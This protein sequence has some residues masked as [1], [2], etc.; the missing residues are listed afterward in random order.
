MQRPIY[1]R[2]ILFLLLAALLFLSPNAFAQVAE[3]DSVTFT[4]EN[5]LQTVPQQYEVLGIE[6]T[7][8]TTTRR[9]F[10]IS[11]L[12]FQTGSTIT[13][14]GPDVSSAIERLYRTGLFTNI[15]IIRQRTTPEGIYLEVR[16][17]ERPKLETYFITGVGGSERE[18]IRDRLNIL[19]GFAVT[20]ATKVQ[21]VNTIQR[22]F[23]NE[24]HW[25]TTVDVRTGEVD[26]VRNTVILYFDVNPGE[27]LE[28]K[29][30]DFRGNEA[31]GDGDLQDA[32][33]EI[34]EDKWW[35]F[36][37]K[38]TI[39]EEKLETAKQNLETFYEAHG[40]L[41]FRITADSV[42]TFPYIQDRLF[43]FNT[44]ATG[45]KV[46][47]SVFE[48]EQYHVSDINWVGNTL[49]TDEQLSEVLGFEQGDVFNRTEFEQ[50]LRF[51]QGGADVTSLYQNRGYLFFT[52]REEIEFVADDSV[53]VTINI[54]EG[55]IATIDE[56]S[57]TGNVETH[58][59]VIRRNLHTIP[60]NTYSR[61]AVIRTVREL[62]TIGYF[63][64]AS[65]RPNLMP[66]RENN[67]VDI[68]Y[69]V[70]P[71]QSTDT[72]EFSGGYG[73]SRI[74]LILSA[75]VS[76]GNFSL[77]RA[78]NGEGWNPIPSGD[79]QTLSL[80][81]QISG[82]GYQSYSFSFTEPW[83][84]GRP[85]SLGISASYNVLSII[86][87]D[88]TNKLL[89]T[90]VS[91]GRRLDWPD[92]YFTQQTILNYRLYDISGGRFLLD[93][94]RSATLGLTSVIERNSLDN[95]IS[96]TR[97]SKLQLTTAVGIPVP[98][99]RQYYKVESLFAWHTTLIGKLV[100][101]TS[102]QYGYL[103]YFSD[104]NRSNFQRYVLGGTPLQQ[105]QSFLTDNIS[106]RG[107]PGGR[108]Q[109]IAPRICE[110]NAPLGQCPPRAVRQVGGR[111]FSKYSLELRIPLV[112]ERQ[113][114]VIPYTFFDA[115]NAYLNFET[116]A[117][118]EVKRAT[119]FG[120]RIYLP[121]LGL[122]DLS[123]GYR[124]DSIPATLLDGSPTNDVMAGEWQF[125]FNLGTSF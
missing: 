103:G 34:K 118:F 2:R 15:K 25:G 106:L 58:D 7:G 92:D 75:R 12:G 30:I 13:V 48:G 32:L 56:V 33:G 78:L 66:N 101:T 6:V 40:Y 83:L 35:K 4:I 120:V 69:T 114:Q 21:G 37:S 36:F 38:K 96:P 23:K 81:I 55:E 73:G 64:P 18:D 72:F 42:Y 53:D 39:T 47:L 94:G 121:I 88:Q 5:P 123:Y 14:P 10:V 113:I 85:N 54:Y 110:I 17:Q 91:L 3:D 70:E 63:R 60:G 79:G 77:E 19:P 102:V 24:G 29:D 99:L 46:R 11:Q 107:Y 67:T 84:A 26:T 59:N 61:R 22:Y 108:G 122:V 124:L 65:I 43:F 27:R 104:V 119:G 80:G 52:A 82:N 16:L 100:L 31:F 20:K 71:S 49:Y 98:G 28:V 109:G 115:G 89:S 97:G 112:Q 105:R 62:G 44:P 111:L 116:F 93:E 125:L 41:D 1:S 68:T 9:Q 57:F 76:F 95:F 117:P 50:N 51:S 74:G 8:L 86:G 90:S 45:I 87:S